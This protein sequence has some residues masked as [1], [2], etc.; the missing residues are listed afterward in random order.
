MNTHINK[1]FS[2]Y[3]LHDS[4]KSGK[5]TYP[6]YTTDSDGAVHRVFERTT[7]K[8]REQNGSS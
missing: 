5:K 6:T 7:K 8:W 3:G 2:R 1:K 4:F